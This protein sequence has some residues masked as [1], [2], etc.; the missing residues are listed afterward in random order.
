MSL[1]LWPRYGFAS[2]PPRAI[3]RNLLSPL[4]VR[5]LEKFPSGLLHRIS[6]SFRSIY[7]APHAP[8]PRLP[9]VSTTK[10]EKSCSGLPVSEGNRGL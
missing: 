7:A 10:C 3:A 1:F 2:F 4:P 9:G 6:I 8:Y 5:W